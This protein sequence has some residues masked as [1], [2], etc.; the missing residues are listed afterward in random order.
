MPAT[1]RSSLEAGNVNK[2]SSAQ[3][4]PA[5]LRRATGWPGARDTFQSVLTVISLIVMLSVLPLQFQADDPGELYRVKN[6]TRYLAQLDMSL[7]R[8]LLNREA[9]L[10]TRRHSPTS[11][12][13]QMDTLLMQINA[14]ALAADRHESMPE[15]R[16]SV[17][18][19]EQALKDKKRLFN[20]FMAE[21][22]EVARNDAATMIAA[23]SAIPTQQ[24][25]DILDAA[26][27][28]Q[29]GKLAQKNDIYRTLLLM[30]SVILLFYVIDFVFRLRRT[31]NLL[32]ETV[33]ELNLQKH[34]IDQHAIVS[35]TNNQGEIIY[36]NARFCQASGYSLDEL[37]GKKKSIIDSGFHPKAFFSSILATI[38]KGEV[39]HGVL[40]H[41]G[42]NGE[43]YW[44]DTTIVPFMN[45]HGLYQYVSISS[46]ITDLKNAEQAQQVSETRYRNLVETAPSAIAVHQDS[47]WVFINPAAMNLFATNHPEELIGR[48]IIDFSPPGQPSAALQQTHD[49]LCGHG[50]ASMSQESWLRVNGTPF[51]AEVTCM[52]VSWKDKPAVMVMV[53]DI[54]ERKRVEAE[55]ANQR[56]TMKALLDHA[57]I[58]IWML[59]IDRRMKFTNKFFNETFGISERHFLDAENYEKL[60]PLDVAR[61]WR[62]SDEN[63]FENKEVK[64]S[65]RIPCADRKEHTFEVIKACVEDEQGNT[66]GL[67]GLVIDATERLEM[68]E[69][70]QRI[71]NQMEHAQR[72][73]S[74]GVLAGGIAHDFN[75]I[76][77]AI[78]G[79]AALANVALP[80][81]SP[82]REHLKNIGRSADRAAD[83]CK[84]M[85]AYSG[86]GQFIIQP[87]NLSKLVREMSQLLSVSISKNVNIEYKLEQELDAIDADAAQLQ[88]V[89]MNLIINASEAIGENSGDITIACGTTEIQPG[90]WDGQFYGGPLR[91]G[92]YAYLEVSDTGCGMD[93]DTQ[94]KMFDPFFTTKFT[95]RGL[96]MS[97]VLGI[98]RSHKGA[99]NIDSAL[100][101]GSTF[102]V[103][104]P[105]IEGKVALADTVNETEC[106][107]WRGS[108]TVLV[109]DDEEQ[110]RNI[111]SM[112]LGKMG[113][114][115]LTAADGKEGVDVFDQHC[116]KIDVVLLDMTMPKMNGLECFRQ[117]KRI[118]PEVKVI[119]SS[120][121]NEQDATKTFNADELDGFI[122]KPYASE[123]L[124]NAL[125]GIS[126]A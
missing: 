101:K 10:I 115:V 3:E 39:W 12:L 4:K 31:R 35:A 42:K 5:H 95:G 21:G 73:E 29:L 109:V 27:S 65:I 64:H 124:K 120:G 16:A 97:A 71:Q 67:V 6:I 58:G 85:L 32:E 75:N 28:N 112:L 110:I 87:I 13:E 43:R 34:A 2:H 100:G 20:D 91:A 114:S 17:V 88:Q 116:G 119:L 93:E 111:A 113:Y 106:G 8:N 63:C 80:A 59:G 98:V 30:L 78:L 48:P 19:I 105:C 55:L 83:L 79:N 40:S 70:Q 18:A 92:R 33:A 76:L 50:S 61:Y 107:D 82:A 72:L 44:V 94:A 46:D 52:P 14:Y 86:K 89:I 45:E 53:N 38:S 49:D 47:K 62:A 7:E 23:I 37:I 84:Q 117:I 126:H 41:R 66:Q 104:F 60:F 26:I 56:S 24:H 103:L 1:D 25:I 99:L 125:R 118:D 121:Y 90:Q 22:V 11:V 74:L 57:P 77:T 36:A 123:P 54:S 108:G 51:K 96:G 69:A 68:E 81:G 102:K 15:I 9:G 122:Q